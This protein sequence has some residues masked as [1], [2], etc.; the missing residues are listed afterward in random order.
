M[1][2]G[3]WEWLYSCPLVDFVEEVRCHLGVVGYAGHLSESK[4]VE[5]VQYL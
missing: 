5:D 1:R 4:H 2:V 3:C